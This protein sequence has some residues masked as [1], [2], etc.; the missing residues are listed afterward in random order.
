MMNATEK[1]ETRKRWVQR[2]AYAVKVEVEVVFPA[3]APEEAC[4]ELPRFDGWTRSLVKLKK[5]IL[6]ICAKL[7][8]SFKQSRHEVRLVRRG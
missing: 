4:L 5:A 3:D 6:S 7:D 1:R 8:E 2:G